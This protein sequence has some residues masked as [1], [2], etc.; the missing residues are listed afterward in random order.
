M[1][2][3]FY[4]ESALNSAEKRQIFETAIFSTEYLWDSNPDYD[5]TDMGYKSNDRAQKALYFSPFIWFEFYDFRYYHRNLTIS[6][7]N[8]FYVFFGDKIWLKH[9]GNLQKLK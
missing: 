3:V 4:S 5:K 6:S 2:F 1:F 8:A 7:Q 9:I